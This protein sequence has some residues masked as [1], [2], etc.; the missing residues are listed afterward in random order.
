MRRD[1][2]VVVGLVVGAALAAAEPVVA[3]EPD[4]G[5][6]SWGTLHI[7]PSFIAGWDETGLV[8]FGGGGEWVWPDGLGFSVDFSLLAAAGDFV[9]G[10]LLISP[11]IIYEFPTRGKLRPFV[12]GGVSLVNFYFP[13][14]DLGG[15]VNYWVTERVGV[16]GELRH[17]LFFEE[18]DTGITS[19]R[20]GVNLRF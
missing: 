16:K 2:M 4:W 11:A 7:G 10:A 3:Q 19:L 18:P 15:G 5:R 17:H 20:A 14:A 6:R 1:R 8:E 13:M 9:P 12:R